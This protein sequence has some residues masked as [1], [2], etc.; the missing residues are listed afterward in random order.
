M[1]E[2]RI[3]R[4]QT[5]SSVTPTPPPPLGTLGLH[6]EGVDPHPA[7]YETTPDRTLHSGHSTGR[8]GPWGGSTRETSERD[9]TTV[10]T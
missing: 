8:P 9:G 10:L 2:E 1:E 6:G 3:S 5:L 7:E 4:P